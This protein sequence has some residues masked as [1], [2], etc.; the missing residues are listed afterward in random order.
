MLQKV[1]EVQLRAAAAELEAAA[2]SHIAAA[3]AE[4]LERGGKLIA[5]G[6]GGSATDAND[7]VS[8]WMAR[9]RAGA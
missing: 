7:L 5:F 4:R 2:I 9:H 3:I 1:Q 8:D 6:N